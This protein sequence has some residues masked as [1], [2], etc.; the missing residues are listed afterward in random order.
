MGDP[1]TGSLL[2]LWTGGDR[3]AA[4][5]MILMYGLNSR[6]MGWWQ[7]VT[8][9]IWGPSQSLVVEDTEVQEKVSEMR[10]AG[11]RVAACRKCAEN[12]GVADRLTELGCEVFYTGEFLTDW[13]KSGRPILAL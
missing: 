5:N 8:L 1:D 2:I 7:E 12:L 10:R 13:L 6:L 4:L 3:E 9:L 11:V